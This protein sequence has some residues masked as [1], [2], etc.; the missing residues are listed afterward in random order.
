MMRY[1]HQDLNIVVVG[2]NEALQ[3]R[4]ISLLHFYNHTLDLGLKF[5]N[6]FIMFVIASLTGSLSMELAP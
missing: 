6:V 2:D 5:L 1:C 3:G 4:N